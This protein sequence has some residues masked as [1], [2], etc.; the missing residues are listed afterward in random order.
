MPVK[1]GSAVGGGITLTATR[2]FAAWGVS[3]FLAVF[4]GCAAF[5][6]G[7]P[8]TTV[9]PPA[10]AEPGRWVILDGANNTRDIG[11]YRTQ[12]GRSVKW[13][14]VYR[15]GELPDLTPAG[16]EAFRELGIRHVVDFRNRL[17]PSPLFGGDAVCVFQAA[18]VDLFPVGGSGADASIPAYVQAVRDNAD[19]YR[20]AFEL[21][22]DPGNL[23]ILYHCAAGKDRTGIMIGLLLTMLGVDRQ[24]VIDD[25]QLSD[26]VG[27]TVN[28]QAMTDLLDAV[29]ADGGI[30]AYLAGIG[31][32][33]ATQATIRAVLLE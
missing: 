13:G 16:C 10:D 7:V 20:R 29:D 9:L 2:L 19:S 28:L 5:D 14:M 4:A 11:G 3:T 26:L 32:S 25:Y 12:D 8:I 17:A 27:A 24:T 30:E 33:P 15:S 18:P 22:A 1:T 6:T 23:P 31:V 21:L